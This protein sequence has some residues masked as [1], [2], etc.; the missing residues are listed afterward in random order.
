MTSP[1][2]VGTDAVIILEKTP[3][4]EEKLSDLLKKHVKLELQMCNDIY[5]TYHLYPPPELSGE[6][7]LV[8]GKGWGA[9][10]RIPAG[11]RGAD[12]VMMPH[13]TPFCPPFNSHCLFV[14]ISA[15][16]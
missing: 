16:F 11:S 10:C 8:S 2:S 1:S 4:Q 15:V 9:G 13:F 12:A 6:C 14:D 3:F 7:F 5:S